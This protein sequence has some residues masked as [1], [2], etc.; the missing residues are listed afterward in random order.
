MSTQG[1]DFTNIVDLSGYGGIPRQITLDTRKKRI[2]GCN[3]GKLFTVTYDGHG[4]GLLVTGSRMH[5]VT[6]DQ[7]ASVLYYT[8]Q[9]KLMKW[10]LSRNLRTE[11]TRVNVLPWNVEVHRGIIYISGLYPSTIDVVSY[12][13]G[14]YSLQSIDLDFLSQVTMCLIP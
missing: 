10:K 3:G 13:T 2:Y 6:L 9:K 7:A 5:A 11:V 14:K 12:N 1:E 8:V 4:L